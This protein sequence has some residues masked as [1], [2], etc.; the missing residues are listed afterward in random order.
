MSEKWERKLEVTHVPKPGPTVTTGRVTRLSTVGSRR[1]GPMRTRMT[2]GVKYIDPSRMM[3]LMPPTVAAS[4]LTFRRRIELL[5]EQQF[6]DSLKK[7]ELKEKAENEVRR[8]KTKTNFASFLD[9]LGDRSQPKHRKAL[10]TAHKPREKR[11]RPEDHSKSESIEDVI[12]DEGS[13][14]T[15]VR[16]RQHK[17]K[18]STVSCYNVLRAHEPQASGLQRPR[19]KPLDVKSIA[20]TAKKRRNESEETDVITLSDSSPSKRPVVAKRSRR[21]DKRPI[22]VPLSIDNEVFSGVRSSP[23]HASS[24]ENGDNPCNRRRSPEQATSSQPIQCFAKDILTVSANASNNRTDLTALSDDELELKT[25]PRESRIAVSRQKPPSPLSPP[26]TSKRIW[27]VE[28]GRTS[29]VPSQKHISFPPVDKFELDSSDD[30]AIQ[31]PRPRRRKKSVAEAPRRPASTSRKK[32]RSTSDAKIEAKFASATPTSGEEGVEGIPDG[33]NAQED[34]PILVVRKAALQPVIVVDDSP[35]PKRR[36]SNRKSTPK[37]RSKPSSV[38]P[39]S[40]DRFYQRKVRRSM[41]LARQSALVTESEEELDGSLEEEIRFRLPSKAERAQL[42][43][44]TFKLDDEEV[45][46]RIKEANIELKAEDFRRLGGSCWLSDE[47]INSFVALV[48]ERNQAYCVSISTKASSHGPQAPL[49][50][51][52]NDGSSQPLKDPLSEPPPLELKEICKEGPSSEEAE[53]QDVVQVAEKSQ[54]Y[55]KHPELFD[56]P[57]P[58]AHIFNTFFYPRL[59]QGGYD[60][61]G[62]KRWLKRAGRRITELDLIMV[63]ININN[64]HWV[65]AAIDMRGKRFLYFDSTYGPDCLHSLKILRRWLKDEVEDKCGKEKVDNMDIDSWAS[66]TNPTYV[67]RQLDDGSCGIFAIYMAEFLERGIKPNFTQQ[68][69]RAL[70]QRTALFLINCQLPES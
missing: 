67:P 4:R 62:V 6:G 17:R 15:S 25:P 7:T 2:S 33:D 43:A 52:M 38:T 68:N 9:Q 40:P 56:M 45:V 59:I 29:P 14:F 39:I 42:S 51:A 36:C 11:K 48:N 27:N 65:L 31:I 21:T 26:R 66:K 22:M 47:L 28:H 10:G 49:S 54:G 46:A 13:A 61:N 12:I 44:L 69:I 63:P 19:R 37:S 70:R 53:S 16:S 34:S 41:R 60:Y 35:S 23:S 58:R 32:N 55:N 24:S 64:I 1:L 18:D 8:R 50:E 20:G 57:R 30:R 3:K 5:H